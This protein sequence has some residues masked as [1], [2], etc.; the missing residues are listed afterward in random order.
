MPEENVPGAETNST[1][2]PLIHPPTEA[3]QP[4]I[5]RGARRVAWVGA[6]SAAIS[7]AIA[8]AALTFSYTAQKESQDLKFNALLD[9]AWDALGGAPNTSYISGF[10]NSDIEKAR[11]LLRDAE[12]IQPG[13][14]RLKLVNAA[15]YLALPN[16]KLAEAERELRDA[17][18]ASPG[19]FDF[20]INLAVTLRMQKKWSAAQ[21]EFEYASSLAPDDA[22]PYFGL[23]NLFRMKGELSTAAEYYLKGI[24]VDEHDPFL[25]EALGSS[26]L[27]LE[28]LPAGLA[29]L[30]EA[31]RLLPTSA[32]FRFKLGNAYFM[33]S[34]F[35]NATREFE[36][37]I[38]LAPGQ[39]DRAYLNLGTLTFQQ[40][41]YEKA[42]AMLLQALTINP[43]SAE[44]NGNLGNLYL[45]EGKPLKAVDHLNAAIEIEPNAVR[46]FNLG[47]AYVIAGQQ[48]KA[49]DAYLSATQSDSDS[50]KVRINLGRILAGERRFGEALEQFAEA[51]RIEPE[52]PEARN[53]LGI[54][55]S[56]TNR[57]N[58]AIKEFDTA[59]SIDPH[60]AE[61]HMNIGH[62]LK[63]VGNLRVA[64]DHYR[65]A[66]RINP[67]LAKA[68]LALGRLLAENGELV[69]ATVELRQSVVL[70]PDNARS[71][72]YLGTVLAQSQHFDEAIKES[73]TAL[74]LDPAFPMAKVNLE[75]AIRDKEA[76]EK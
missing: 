38:R 66:L 50:Y 8:L 65:K 3:K 59:L 16:P 18:A 33:R 31:V 29:R 56:V 64:E 34:Q 11:R 44:A 40:G 17:I 4:T 12:A 41:D 20:H 53:D 14:P 26:L 35:Q 39:F 71:H 47:N 74:T 37:V 45:K 72:H 7:A 21:K 2:A 68:R 9:Q 67:N 57:T 42:E 70:E 32:E 15:M 62:T 48:E 69:K 25:Q 22:T 1:T 6:L 49:I 75:Q 27:Q 5:D 30:R 76:S 13:E 51:V 61:T 36:E 55:F 23:G 54:V 63:K 46:Y 43:N 28:D 24:N 10:R 52:N 58:E 73:Y 19:I 60:S